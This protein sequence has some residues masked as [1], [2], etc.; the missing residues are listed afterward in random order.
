M[1][2]VKIMIYLLLAASDDVESQRK[3]I[4]SVVWPGVKFKPKEESSRLKLDRIVFMKNVYAS[5][6]I[7]TASLHFCF[8][9]SPFI[10]VYR[11]MLFLSMPTFRIRMK[12]HSGKLCF[13]QLV[14]SN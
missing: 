4:T 3:G 2:Q 14:H 11:A 5:L 9:D 6:P 12:F 7:R 8:P 13:G 10:N 1:Q